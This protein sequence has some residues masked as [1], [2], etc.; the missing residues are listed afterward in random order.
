VR[1]VR[2][3]HAACRDFGIMENNMTVQEILISQIKPNSQNAKMHSA[4]QVRQIANSITVFGFTSP[5][6]ISDDGE[7]IAGHGR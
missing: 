4:K 7:L 2:R 6:L 3:R 5:L 1:V